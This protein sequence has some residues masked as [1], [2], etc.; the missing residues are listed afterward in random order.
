MF[1][2]T[3]PSLGPELYGSR[4][5]KGG[6]MSTKS[7]SGYQINKDSQVII[8]GVHLTAEYVIF[9]LIQISI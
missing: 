2:G 1:V 8:R 5:K 7:R 3:S 9:P 6:L 4:H